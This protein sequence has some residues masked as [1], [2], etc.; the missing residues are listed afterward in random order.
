MRVFAISGYSGS[1]KTTLTEVLIKEMVEEGLS[2][3]T[4][5]SSKHE[6]GPEEGSDTWR[7]IQAGASM[8]L[9]QKASN[10]Q[11]NI[12]E[13]IGKQNL[14]KLAGHD[15]LIIEGMKSID[16]PR[17]W[18]IGDSD[19]NLDDIPAGTQ[20]IVTWSVRPD[21]ITDIPILTQDDV[22]HLV[23]IVKTKSELI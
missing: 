8:T 23:E 12:R 2:V 21:L 17:F 10:D 22:K 1:G 20:A 5:K 11:T 18:C 6:A 14:E 19:F 3:A 16:I 4:M 9:F 15:F 13:R 7:H